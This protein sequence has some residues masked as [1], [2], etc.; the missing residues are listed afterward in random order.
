[1]DFNNFW[2]IE[3]DTEVR[4]RTGCEPV[5][6]LNPQ[7]VKMHVRAL[8]DIASIKNPHDINDVVNY[9]AIRKAIYALEDDSHANCLESH[10]LKIVRAAFNIPKIVHVVVSASKPFIYMGTGIPTVSLAIDRSTWEQGLAKI[11]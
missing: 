10:I 3:V 11:L 7:L 1:M 5:E 8:I 6:Q 4:I 2:A 9:D